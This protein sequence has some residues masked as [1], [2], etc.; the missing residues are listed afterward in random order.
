MSAFRGKT[1]IA[2]I[3]SP[4]DTKRP[5]ASGVRSYRRRNSK[6]WYSACMPGV[7]LGTESPSNG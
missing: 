2:E 4:N 3:L 7:A 6:L 1:G 5:S